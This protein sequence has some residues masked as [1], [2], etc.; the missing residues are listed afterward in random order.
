MGKS[1]DNSV[2]DAALNE[3]ADNGTRLCFCSQEPTDYTEAIT[4]YKL[5]DLD[6]LTSG[7]YTGPADGDT[8][9]RKLTVDAQTGITVDS[10]GTSNHVAIVD[11]TNTLLLYVTTHTG[12]AVTS[13]NTID[14]SAWDIEIADPT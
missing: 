12:Q 3:I 2:L 6:G 14:M 4:T 8:N 5:A 11:V 7:D 9:G 10:D 13:G 1:V